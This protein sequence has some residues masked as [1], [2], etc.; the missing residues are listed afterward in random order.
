[1]TTDSPKGQTAGSIVSPVAP[2]APLNADAAAAPVDVTPQLRRLHP[3]TP[4]L[5]SWRLLGGL[6]AA[7]LGLF[8]D[9]VENLAWIWHALQG[10]AEFGGLP[11]A[12]GL[13]MFS[14][15]IS[16]LAA[17]LSWRATGFAFVTDSNGVGTLLFHRGL[18]VRHRSQVRLKRVQSVDVNQ[19]LVPRLLGLSALRLDMAA[20]EGASV[21]LAYLRSADA[22]HLR[23]EILC[24]TAVA[25][26]G[27]A[28]EQSVARP[29]IRDPG[30]A[31]SG[32]HAAAGLTAAVEAA[33]P[34]WHDTRG[35][36]LVAQVS[37]HHLVRANLLDG[38]S[39]WLL[40]VAWLL[41]L[42]VSTVIWGWEALLGAFAVLI[43]VTIAFAAQTSRQIG[44]MLRDANFR[45][46]RT[47]TG[48]RI[49]SGLTS[50]INRT[51]DFDRIQ[52]V[53]LME[54]YLW[55]RFGWAA[56]MVD[57]AGGPQDEEKGAALM[58][59]AE[60]AAALELVA[61]VTGVSLDC[62]SYAS[63]GGGAR[64]LDPLGW[65]YLGV[66]MFAEGVARRSGRWR[67]ST[68]YV[69]F[70]RVQSVTAHQGWLQRRL[71][72]AT[73]YV[74]L[75]VGAKRWDARHRALDDAA[76]LVGELGRRTRAQLEPADEEL[77]G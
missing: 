70:Q 8:R 21:N 69:P 39:A 10:D 43:P 32:N 66:A 31:A 36:E 26:A 55:R 51:I 63:A 49:S 33:S 72:L 1:M 41:G 29:G 71:S 38:V 11:K 53:R 16:A 58:P 24:H 5:R 35:D 14:L 9:Q 42:V 25:S 47:P 46:Y 64:R 62:G 56:V 15:L 7:A 77:V 28:A 50:T 59:V 23:E 73:V 34:A 74:D 45:L 12:F 30:A 54:P 13:V 44:S 75:P 22:W 52:G 48:V 3:L 6:T 37:T 65:R 20:G 68:A 4:V 67:R 61:H 76:N 2:A 18:L 60:R 40:L 27:T 19:P 17:W 57:I